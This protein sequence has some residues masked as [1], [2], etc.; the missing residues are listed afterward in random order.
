VPVQAVQGVCKRGGYALGAAQ[1]RYQAGCA[2]SD[3]ERWAEA[4]P[5]LRR[6]LAA[7]EAERGA[8]HLDLASVCNGVPSSVTISVLSRC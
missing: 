5:V 1:C 8:D 6:S 4:A 7:L 3:Q 2:L